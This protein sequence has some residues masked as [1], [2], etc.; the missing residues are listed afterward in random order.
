ML[1]RIALVSLFA[2]FGFIFV[3]CDKKPFSSGNSNDT[4]KSTSVE[5]PLD[6]V[7]YSDHYITHPDKIRIYVITSI[8]SISEEDFKMAPLYKISVMLRGDGK[9]YTSV[10]FT[11]PQDKIEYKYASA[12]ILVPVAEDVDVWQNK[13]KEFQ[14]M[15]EAN[16]N[17][18][19]IPR[20]VL[21]QESQP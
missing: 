4:P 14:A 18:N 20:R 11:D 21:P 2:I 9:D 13:L 7:R 15:Y 6:Y 5:W 16:R 3:G 19:R 12:I 8:N 10:V 17:L 1:K